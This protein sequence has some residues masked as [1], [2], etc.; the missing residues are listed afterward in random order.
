[1]PKIQTK[2]FGCYLILL[3]LGLSQSAR[4]Q[5]GLDAIQKNMA[6]A[7]LR[8]TLMAHGWAP[9]SNKKIGQSSLYALEI[10]EQGYTEV[11]DCISMALDGCTFRFAKNNKMLEINTITRQLLVESHTVKKR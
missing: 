11:V 3:L 7:D 5:D 8:P 6:Y 9:V 2:P 10:Y 4:A 1:M